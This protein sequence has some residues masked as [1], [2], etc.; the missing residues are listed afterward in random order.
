MAGRTRAELEPLIGFFVNTI[1]VRLRLDQDA[2]VA[3][4]VRQ[5][6]AQVLAAQDHGDL[7][8]EQVVET[9]QPP[10]TLAHAP[11][12]QVMFAWQNVPDGGLELPGLQVSALEGR[13]RTAQFD[14]T[15]E[16]WP[17]EQGIRGSINYSTALF[18]EGTVRRY[19]EY[20]QRFVNAMAESDEQQVARVP[21]LP[22]SERSRLLVEWN[23][24]EAEYPRERCLHELFEMQ[25]ARSAHATAVVSG[26]ERVSYGE[27]NARAN[28]LAHRLR[29]LGVGPDERVGVC[30]ER[31]VPMVV[32]L[33]AVLKAGGAYVPL[34][35]TYPAERLG[36]MV[37]DSNPRVLL[38]DGRGA[39]PCRRCAWAASRCRSTGRMREASRERPRSSG[40]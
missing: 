11:I 13:K 8:F 21:L 33:L 6:R 19:A 14:L 5:A 20:F 30:L 26:E 12:F 31:G 4:L 9:V 3:E 16:L 36:F 28:R 39:G 40:T 15:L 17:T 1:A 27:L 10:R 34:D 35:P 7:P 25:A 37:E 18:D 38:V 22:A 32:S 29:K 2:T 24:T 23:A